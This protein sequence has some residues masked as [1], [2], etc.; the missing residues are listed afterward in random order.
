M[1]C[2]LR[3]K[4]VPF[5]FN[6][7]EPTTAAGTVV[8]DDDVNDPASPSPPSVLANLVTSGPK[9]VPAR[10]PLANVSSM[11]CGIGS[12][13]TAILFIVGAGPLELESSPLDAAA[14]GGSEDM[15][16]KEP[17]AGLALDKA[18]PDDPDD[19]GEASSPARFRYVDLL[20]FSSSLADSLTG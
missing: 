6:L 9:S 17:P 12:G 16:G 13:I 4:I 8:V 15:N 7:P 19:D 18:E 5:F 11:S 1:F 20:L 14:I 2:S 10:L 3:E